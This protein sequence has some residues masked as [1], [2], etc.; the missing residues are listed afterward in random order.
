MVCCEIFTEHKP[1]EESWWIHQDKCFC[2]MESVIEKLTDG[3]NTTV[4]FNTLRLIF[5]YT[6]DSKNQKI[7]GKK[8]RQKREKYELVI[9]TKRNTHIHRLHCVWAGC[10]VVSDSLWP[11]AHRAPLYMGLSRQDYWSELPFPPPENLP[12]PGITPV[13]PTLAGKFTLETS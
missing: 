2:S 1:R 11:L 13:F 3:E 5:K 7:G 12:N 9:H 10:S 4:M 8:P 6:R